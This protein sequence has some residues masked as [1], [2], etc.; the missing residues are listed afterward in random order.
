[1]EQKGVIMI[2]HSEKEMERLIEE[3]SLV[4]RRD[5][6]S[7][8]VFSQDLPELNKLRNNLKKNLSPVCPSH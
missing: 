8:K 5:G 4:Q 3:I 1:M 2:F 7:D 6:T